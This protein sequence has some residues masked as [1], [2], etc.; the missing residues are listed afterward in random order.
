[1]AASGLTK[2]EKRELEQRR[3]LARIQAGIDRIRHDTW[4]T[5]T[6]AAARQRQEA[7]AEVDRRTEE[8]AQ[9]RLNA[10]EW[11]DNALKAQRR[12]PVK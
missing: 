12:P 10:R 8:W 3:E 1:M 6:I 4:M 5:L 7:A 11:L 2:S 9:R